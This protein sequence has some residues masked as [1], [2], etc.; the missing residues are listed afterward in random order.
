MELEWVSSVFNVGAYGYVMWVFPVTKYKSLAV[1]RYMTGHAVFWTDV[2]AQDSHKSQCSTYL[3]LQAELLDI[4]Q[5]TEL[6]SNTVDENKY[7]VLD[8]LMKTLLSARLIKQ[9]YI[10]E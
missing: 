10:L 4:D 6:R 9:I 7:L 5:Y 2:T 1:I 8:Y 3:I